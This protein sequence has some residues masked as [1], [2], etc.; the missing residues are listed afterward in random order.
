MT[1]NEIIKCNV[2]EEKIILRIQ[3]ESTDIPFYTKCPE[4][5]IKISGRVSFS[6]GIKMEVKGASD[7]LPSNE[8]DVKGKMWC[9]ELSNVF[10]TYKLEKISFFSSPTPFIRGLDLIGGVDKIP[11]LQSAFQLSNFIENDYE[12]I[13][14]CYELHWNGKQELLYP[15]LTSICN[16]SES[17]QINTIQNDLDAS[18][19]LHQLFLTYSGVTAFLPDGELEQYSKINSDMFKY[20]Y[21]VFLYTKDLPLDLFEKRLFELFSCFFEIYEQMLPVIYIDKK[22]IS[23]LDLKKYGVMT[24]NFD[25]LLTFYTKSYELILEYI[26]LLIYCNNIMHRGNH[27]SFKGNKTHKNFKSQVLKSRKLK[28]LEEGEYFSKLNEELDSIVRN[29]IQHYD[30]SFDSITQLITFT[31]KGKTTSTKEMYLIEFMGMC[32]ENYILLLYL[33][34]VVYTLKKNKYISN[35][36]IPSFIFEAQKEKIYKSKIGRNDPCL[37][38]SGIKFKKCCY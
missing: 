24:G 2:C 11:K 8:L 10:P 19:G 13:Y 27:E 34:E 23:K 14:S 28:Y 16:N 3:V 30:Y 32:K 7:Y 31:N 22:T 37:C 18:M 36:L 25:D 33:F 21:E 17:V 38:G 29:S 35:G 15:M 5:G 6:E 9:L 12:L 26:D 20:V 1:K 4:C